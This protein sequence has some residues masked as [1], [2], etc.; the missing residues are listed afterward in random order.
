MTDTQAI[1]TKTKV[2]RDLA[3]AFPK[4]T[5]SPSRIRY[6]KDYTQ[7]FEVQ[8]HL[9]NVVLV[10]DRPRSMDRGDTARARSEDRLTAYGDHLTSLGYTVVREAAGL[11][12]TRLAVS[13]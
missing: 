7:G 6:V 1:A 4:S 10:I 9:E 3:K 13:L 11:L 12:G 8:S 5:A 2:S